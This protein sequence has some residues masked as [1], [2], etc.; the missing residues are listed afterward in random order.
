MNDTTVAAES[1]GFKL[2]LFREVK[3]LPSE[4]VIKLPETFGPKVVTFLVLVL[5]GRWIMKP[6]Q[7]KPLMRLN[8]RLNFRCLVAHGSE[9]E[10]LSLIK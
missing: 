2:K 9:Y 8:V 4:V 3:K 10:S 7:T 5:V 1:S 6:Y